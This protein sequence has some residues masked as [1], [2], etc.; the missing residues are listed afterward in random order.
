MECSKHYDDRVV[1]AGHEAVV[2][3]GASHLLRHRLA[4]ILERVSSTMTSPDRLRTVR[5]VFSMR[6]S[7]QITDVAHLPW[8]FD[9]LNEM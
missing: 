4:F 8:K 1:A 2:G 7:K 9:E 5:L 3:Q 6:S